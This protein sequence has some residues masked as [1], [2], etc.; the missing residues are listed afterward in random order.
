MNIETSGSVINSNKLSAG[1]R[2]TISAQNVDNQ[3]AGRLSSAETRI[4]AS[5]KITN[6][7]LINSFTENNDSKTVLKATHIDNVGSGRIYGD[8]VALQADK[9]ENHDGKNIAGEVKSATIAARHRLSLLEKKSLIV[10][11]FMRKTKKVVQLFTVGGIL[12]LANV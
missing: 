7:G 1:K 10:P 5:G 6:Q 2:L 3:E 8:H 12:N 11:L 9:I 4:T